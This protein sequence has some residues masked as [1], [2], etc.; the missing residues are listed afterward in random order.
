MNAPHDTVRHDPTAQRFELGTGE[1]TGLVDYQRVGARVV[2][3]HT[4]VP[5]VLRGKGVAAQL[6]RAALTWAR[7]EKLMVVPQCSYIARFIERHHEYSDL[8]S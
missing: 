5:P 3:T 4:F 8:V 7:A 2:F 1:K 6:A